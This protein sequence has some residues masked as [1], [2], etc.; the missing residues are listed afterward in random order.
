L[1][2]EGV[3]SY[4]RM[5]VH[6]D[7][8][9]LRSNSG[10]NSFATRLFVEFNNQGHD[11]IDRGVDADVSLVFIEPSGQPLAKKVVQRLDG[12]W[13]KPGE[14]NTKNA[15]IKKL[16]ERADAI[17]FQS[18]FDRRMI[19]KWWGSNEERQHRSPVIGNGIKL[20]PINQVTIPELARLR[21][22]YEKVFVCSANW[23]AQKRL[24]SNIELFDHLRKTQFPKSCLFIMGSNPDV[25]VTD[26]HVFYTGS[27]LPEVYMQVFAVAD[28]MIHLAWADHCPNVVVEALSQGTPI[29]C[30]E[31]GGTK[32]MIAHG[33]Y[34]VVLK[35]AS[36]DFELTDYDN[37]PKI[38]VT[39]VTFLPSRHELDYAAIPTI[40]ISNVAN[41]YIDLFKSIQ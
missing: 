8:V 25:Q 37:P 5:K 7:N 30:G 34:G 33:A 35:E 27:Q 10:P 31:V 6:F 20:Q 12:I 32:E 9:N 14:F 18:L 28:W 36:Y 40:D 1:A 13:F 4:R 23:H 17:V 38:D 26:P 16:Y 3:E 22:S 15:G 24:R 39:Q 21:A 11:V 2:I 19:E 29:I 41:Q